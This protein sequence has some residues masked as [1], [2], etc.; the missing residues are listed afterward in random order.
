ME[1]GK[2]NV[3]VEV[4]VEVMAAKAVA[5]ETLMVVGGK[6]TAVV[7]VAEALAVDDYW[8]ILMQSLMHT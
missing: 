6:E 1:V 4:Q 5:K 2:T 3:A 8:M 7:W